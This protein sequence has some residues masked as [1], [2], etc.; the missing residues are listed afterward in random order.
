MA[1]FLQILCGD[2]VALPG[3]PI[4]REAKCPLRRPDSI[5]KE[6]ITM[7]KSSGNRSPQADRDNRANQMNPN[8]DAYWQARGDD[9]RPGDWATRSDDNPSD[10][11]SERK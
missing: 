4:I 6:V 10:D 9:E 8:N 2:F 7:A 3:S 11:A 1:Y 5:G